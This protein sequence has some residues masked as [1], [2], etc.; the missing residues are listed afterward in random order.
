MLVGRKKEMKYIW[1]RDEC[2][3]PIIHSDSSFN[4]FIE[5]R[6]ATERDPRFPPALL[7]RLALL[8]LRPGHQDGLHLQV[9]V[10]QPTESS[11]HVRPSAAQVHAGP[12]DRRLH[13]VSG[14]APRCGTGLSAR[15]GRPIDVHQHGIRA[16]RFSCLP[17]AAHHL[18]VKDYLAF[19][20][21]KRRPELCLHQLLLA[22]DC[23]VPIQS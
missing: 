22:N 2:H 23:A 13:P 21:W 5:C 7:H 18:R 12:L 9:R 1:Q 3:W 17:L 15:P 19:R 11:S 10:G 4:L 6:N 14:G 8:C 16:P 20:L